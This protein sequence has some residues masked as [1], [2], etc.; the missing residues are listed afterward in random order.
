MESVP[1][2]W[3]RLLD[4]EDALILD[5]ETTGLKGDIEIVEIGIINTKG[6]VLLHRYSMPKKEIEP[7]A[8]ATH[9]LSLDVLKQKQAKGWPEIHAEV[10]Q[11]LS[12]AAGVIMYNAAFDKRALAST[13]RINNLTLPPIRTHCAMLAYARHRNVLHPVHK[14]FRWHKLESAAKHEG[15]NVRRQHRAVDDCQIVLAMMGAV[16]KKYE[17]EERSWG[18]PYSGHSE[19][20]K[21]EAKKRNWGWRRSSA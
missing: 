18:S 1:K 16:V 4:R 6:D 5:T 21:H 8:E 2:A 14:G 7:S 20:E 15:V 12:A 3:A 10:C 11:V 17:A 19:T 13:A 9:G